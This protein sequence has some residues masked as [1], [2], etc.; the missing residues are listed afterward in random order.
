[1]TVEESEARGHYRTVGSALA[2][3]GVVGLA[4]TFG[5]TFVL[6]QDLGFIEPLA[7]AMI[8]GITLALG[9]WMVAA[10]GATD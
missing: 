10:G 6:P 1:V 4:A 5:V 2:A 3:F 9:A 7:M 8:S